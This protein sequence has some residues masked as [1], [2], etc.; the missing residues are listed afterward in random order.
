VTVIVPAAN[1]AAVIGDVVADIAAQAYVDADG[2]RFDLLVVD[3][4][5]DDDSSELATAAGASLGSRL[6]V[7]QRPP[8]SEPATKG[9]A[10]A[11]AHGSVRGEVVCVLDADARVAPDFLASAVAAWQADAGAAALQVQRRGHNASRSWLAAAQD[12]ELLMDM[13]SQCGRWATDGTAE[14]RGSGGAGGVARGRRPAVA[15]AD[16]L[17]GGQHATPDGARSG[18]AGR[19]PPARWPAT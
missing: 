3:D 12:E 18:P 5:S 17:G 6:R 13:A 16:A 2:P 15:A 19:C 7:L 14:L 8:G 10:L 9:A 4:G 1:E 11:F